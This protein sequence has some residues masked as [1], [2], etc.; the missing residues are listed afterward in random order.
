MLL[1]FVELVRSLGLK[2][3]ALWLAAIIVLT[4][5]MGA[6]VLVVIILR[7]QSPEE[8]SLSVLPRE[9]LSQAELVRL[10]EELQ[11]EPQILKVRYLFEEGS[12][13]GSF[14]ILLPKGQ[15][16]EAVIERL[17]SWGTFTE[18]TR[19]LPEPPGPL[20]ALLQDPQVR[21]LWIGGLSLLTLTALLLTY[22]GLRAC[23]RSFVGELELLRLSGVPPATLYLPFVLAG[24]LYGLS[25]AVLMVMLLYWGRA[26]LEQI[27]P[28]LSASGARET[29]VLY[30]FLFGAVFGGLGGLLGLLALKQPAEA[31]PQQDHHT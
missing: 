5:S 13:Q 16:P 8:I 15:D 11:A 12:P 28:E 29:I 3:W 7:P 2:A 18:V 6:L 14:E 22:G 17:R 21:P 23:V 27:S 9:D 26:W 20:E 4:I 30:G 10:Y 31:Q 1:A 19:S 25:A 24:A